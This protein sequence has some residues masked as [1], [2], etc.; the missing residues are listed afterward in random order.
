[1]RL[2]RLTGL[3]RD[4]IIKDYNEILAQ[5]AELKKILASKELVMQIIK[6]E[7]IEIRDKFGDKRRTQIVDTELDN[8]NV[9]DLIQKEEMVVTISHLGYIKRHPV[10]AYRAQ[11]RGGKGKQGMTTREEDFVEKIFT[12]STHDRMLIFTNRGR[13]HWLK[14]YE[15]PEVS[16]TAKG[17]SISNLIQLG[18]N[19][20]L[21]AILPIESFTTDESVIFATKGGTVKKTALSAY[22]NPRAGGI[23]AITLKNDELIS[24]RLAKKDQDIIMSSAKG[25]AIRFDESQIRSMGRSAAG[26]RGINLKADNIV[27]GMDVVEPGK[28]ILTISEKGYG[29]RT[30][31]EEYRKQSRGGSGIFT[32]KVT[33]KNGKVL[34][35]EQVSEDD[36]LMLI[37]NGGKIIRQEVKNISIIG[38][39][40]QGVRLI[41]LDKNEL[42]VSATIIEPEEG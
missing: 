30:S 4:K 21:A 23:I 41:G 11:R 40:T 15:V 24:V 28:T 33:E 1:M 38:R 16:R 26:V 25:Q 35:A 36:H 14:V 31:L 6:D 13:V 37:T 29:K 7:L 9:E 8:I 18:P 42:V 22:S 32:L 20:K 10:S 19:E 17:K 34:T 12:A 39:N 27:V 2:Q 5:I 3:E